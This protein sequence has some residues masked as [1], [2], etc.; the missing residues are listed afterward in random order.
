MTCQVRMGWGQATQ[1]LLLNLSE[2]QWPLLG[3]GTAQ[4]WGKVPAML[5]VIVLQFL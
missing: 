3:F 2:W 4:V 1:G 5:L